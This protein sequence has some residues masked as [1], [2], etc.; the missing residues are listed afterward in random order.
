M[1]RGGMSTWTAR[2]LGQLTAVFLLSFLFWG[3]MSFLNQNQVQSLRESVVPAREVLTYLGS[4]S[5]VLF[6]FALSSSPNSDS[7][8]VFRLV[9]T[10]LLS[11]TGI[12]VC[13][14][15]EV[16]F[17]REQIGLNITD[18]NTQRLTSIEE[19]LCAMAISILVVMF[20]RIVALVIKVHDLK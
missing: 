17:P 12:L 10:V 9:D 18:G 8:L 2:F 3:L 6:G 11:L 19:F 16:A 20:S 14:C 13:L 5:F 1:N 4:S 15:V 7:N